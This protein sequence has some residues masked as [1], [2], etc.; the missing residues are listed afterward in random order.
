MNKSMNPSSIRS[1]KLIVDALLRL[2]KHKKYSSITITDIANEA[3]IVRKTFYRHFY[4]LEDVLDEY[5]E[6]LFTQY[7][8]ML[9]HAHVQNI[10]EHIPLY[11]GFWQEHLE[12]LQL[13]EQNNLLAYVLQKYN[14]LLPELYTLL[15]CH[16]E[17][18]TLMMEYFVSYTAG[19]FWNLLCKWVA[20][21]GKET[22]EE[23]T[24]IFMHFFSQI[25][26]N[27]LA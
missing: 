24:E 16:M 21:G 9:R 5:V 6:E 25:A 26:D 7:R 8:E 19:G 27:L 20:G 22:P 13:L 2:M 3:Q 4:S 10:Y 15:P 14:V 17:E 1:R 18:N 11:F 23:M 12:F